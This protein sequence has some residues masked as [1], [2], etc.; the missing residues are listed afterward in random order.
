MKPL[1]IVHCTVHEEK[2]I[3]ENPKGCSV[4]GRSAP[5]MTTTQ[6]IPATNTPA[7]TLTVVSLIRLS[8]FCTDRRRHG[9]RPETPNTADF[10]LQTSRPEVL[11][12][13]FGTP[14]A[15][16][17]GQESALAS[18]TLTPAQRRLACSFEPKSTWRTHA[19]G[20]GLRFARSAACKRRSRTRGCRTYRGATC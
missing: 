20:L 3:T 6:S 1:Y 4:I 18:T 5:N 13:T 8:T 14:H 19:G 15:F 2:Y 11:L 7:Y 17:I 9:N 16:D 12:L 10:I